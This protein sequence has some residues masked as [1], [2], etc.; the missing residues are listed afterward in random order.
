MGYSHAHEHSRSIYKEN[1]GLCN[2]YGSW[3]P[4]A[5][6]MGAG[7]IFPTPPEPVPAGRVLQVCTGFFSLPLSLRVCHLLQSRRLELLDSHKLPSTLR[8]DPHLPNLPVLPFLYG[9]SNAQCGDACSSTSFSV[10]RLPSLFLD[11][12]LKLQA[13]TDPHGP[14][15]LTHAACP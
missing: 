12:L 15:S 10:P 14:H 9:S 8:A 7:G 5:A 1:H 3:V 4:V 11:F 2:P 6:G 13:I